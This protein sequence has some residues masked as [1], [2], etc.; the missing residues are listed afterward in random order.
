MIRPLL[1]TDKIEEVTQ[2]IHAAYAAHSE[3]GL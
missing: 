2:V 1:P 3:E